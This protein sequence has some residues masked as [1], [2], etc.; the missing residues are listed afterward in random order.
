MTV[1]L[2]F[3]PCLQ[4]SG[5]RTMTWPTWVVACCDCRTNKR[6]GFSGH[7]E[8]SSH[9]AQGFISGVLFWQ[10]VE[11][12]ERLYDLSWSSLQAGVREVAFRCVR[13][14]ISPFRCVRYHVSP[15][16]TF[17]RFAV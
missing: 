3:A 1:D 4:T 15:C 16:E 17:R 11:K 8:A 13:P 12:E 6:V 5:A 7:E 10:F 9:D 2:D 14:H